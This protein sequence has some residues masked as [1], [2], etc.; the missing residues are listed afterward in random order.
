MPGAVAE[1]AGVMADAA[2]EAEARAAD[3]LERA[4]EAAGCG[5]NEPYVMRGHARDAE[6]HLRIANNDWFDAVL[7]LLIWMR[8][9]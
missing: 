8:Q 3:A 5:C 6:R 1:W 7:D 4:D 2:R 9:P